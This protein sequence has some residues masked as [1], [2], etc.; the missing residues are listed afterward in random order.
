MKLLMSLTAVLL[1]VCVTACG[2]S[3]KE[4]GSISHAS[5]EAAAPY[6]T[7][8]PDFTK[9]DADK[10]NDIG[11]AADDSNNNRVFDYASPANPTDKRAIT[12]LVKRYYAAAGAE[13]GTR[14]CSMLYSTFA[15]SVPEDY[16]RSAGPPYLRGG[17]TCAAVMVLL[18]KHLHHQLSVEIPKLKVTHVRLQQHH[19][20]AALSFGALPERQILVGREG[21]NWKIEM[22]LDSEL[23]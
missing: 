16:G 8:T 15:E 10:D 3:S 1:S 6:P 23:P 9:A 2:G 17:K 11:A 5:S 18:F 12:G 19:G 22:L 4:T 20:L 14:A 21:H 13:D 7:S